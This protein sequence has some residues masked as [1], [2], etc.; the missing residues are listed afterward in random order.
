V[1]KFDRTTIQ[2]WLR[3]WGPAICGAVAIWF[4]S[5]RFFSDEQTAPV[6]LPILR[7]LFPGMTPRMLVLSHK[8]IRKLAHVTVYFIFSLLLWRSI[9]GEQKGWQRSWAL[10]ALG[11]AVGYAVLDEIHQAFVPL[12][13]AA[14]RDVLLDSCGAFAAQVLVWWQHDQREPS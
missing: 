14:I 4:L 13:H 9:R 6:I 7:W 11:I 12:R 10:A 1:R 3:R 5:T 8:A 2:S